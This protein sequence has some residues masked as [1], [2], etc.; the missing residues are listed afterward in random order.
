MGRWRSHNPL[1][2]E[3]AIF[4]LFDI[5]PRPFLLGCIRWRR[6][7]VDKKTEMK[8]AIV[9]VPEAKTEQVEIAAGR[10]GYV[11]MKFSR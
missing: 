2:S 6:S 10:R 3:T 4:R 7:H 8:G 9:R 5:S 11:G 1:A